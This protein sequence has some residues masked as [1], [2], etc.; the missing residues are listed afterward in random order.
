MTLRQ[1][2]L[3]EKKKVYVLTSVTLVE[4]GLHAERLK[5]ELDVRQGFPSA[6][7]MSLPYGMWDLIP[8]CGGKAFMVRP[9]LVLFSLSLCFP[10]PQDGILASEK[11]GCSS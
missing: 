3:S 1:I 4:E 10:P 5:L 7:W 8:P 9:E 11:K 2:S 6:L